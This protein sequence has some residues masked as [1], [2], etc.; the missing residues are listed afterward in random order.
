MG[1]VFWKSKAKVFF[2]ANQYFFS[3]ELLLEATS[4]INLFRG[5]FSV[6]YRRAGYLTSVFY[7]RRKRERGT[8]SPFSNNSAI[9]RPS[10][11]SSFLRLCST[12]E[13]A[14]TRA[15]A[16]CSE[17]DSKKNTHG[18]ISNPAGVF[19][20]GRKKSKGDESLE[21]RC[22]HV[23][24]LLLIVWAA[25]KSVGLTTKAIFSPART[26]RRD[27]I[28]LIEENCYEEVRHRAVIFIIIFVFFWPTAAAE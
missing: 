2:A 4:Q 8:T 10:L 17:G 11:T 28:S 9:K 7:H 20:E 24:F 18:E 26:H 14:Q 23:T 5:H 3:Q 6:G 1:G 13:L 19:H 12:L 22:G 15:P 21:S 16:S 25:F 27:G